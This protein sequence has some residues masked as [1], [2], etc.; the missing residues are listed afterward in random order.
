VTGVGG[1]YEIPI[2][3]VNQVVSFQPMERDVTPNVINSRRLVLYAP[4]EVVRLLRNV[5]HTPY[6]RYLINL[7]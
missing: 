4:D 1:R 7:S 5:R 6:I 3:D 2:W